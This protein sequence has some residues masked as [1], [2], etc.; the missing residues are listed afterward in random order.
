MKIVNSRLEKTH[1]DNVDY[2]TVFLYVH[3]GCIVYCM[4]ADLSGTDEYCNAINLE[5]GCF[6]RVYNNDPIYLVK[7]TLT[8]N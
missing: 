8:I 5:D 4:K 1:I 6:F 3:G 7:A 2:G